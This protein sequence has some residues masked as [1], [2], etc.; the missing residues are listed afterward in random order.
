[1]QLAAI[2][3]TSLR[4]KPLYQETLQVP[5]GTWIHE[6]GHCPGVMY[7]LFSKQATYEQENVAKPKELS[8]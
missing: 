4:S 5:T 1:M 7:D 6:K 8:R 3:K 2:L